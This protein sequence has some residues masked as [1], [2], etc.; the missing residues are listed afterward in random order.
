[1][2]QAGAIPQ[3]CHNAAVSNINRNFMAIRIPSYSEIA[4][5]LKGA[6]TIEA[7]EKIMELRI[8]ALELQEE[9]LNLNTRLQLAE[10]ELR[11]KKNL[12]FNRSIYFMEGDSVPLCPQCFETT[13][14]LIHLVGPMPTHPTPDHTCEAWECHVC[15]NDYLGMDGKEFLRAPNEVRRAQATSPV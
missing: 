2:V 10:A 12:K 9:N 5:L 7:Q 6:I 14:K 13:E 15:Y 3:S 11:Q 8:A 1:M 4:S